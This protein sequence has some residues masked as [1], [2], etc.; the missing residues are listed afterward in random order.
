MADVLN[1]EVRDQV[2]TKRIR[3]MRKTGKIPAVLYGHKEAV[4]NLAIRKEEFAQVLKHSGKLVKLAGS[5]SEDALVREVQWDTYGVNVLHVDL[6][7]VSASERVTTEVTVELRGTAVGTTQGGVVQFITHELE[8]EC[9]AMSIPEK[10]VLNINDL[11]LGKAIHAHEVP[12]PEGVVLTSAP[13]VI[14]VQCVTP[15]V[16]EIPVPGA[17]GTAEPEVIGGKKPGEEEAA[18]TEKK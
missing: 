15:H 9:P 12:L 13:E 11:A 16:E 8:I 14:V 2:G 6:M 1:V 17:G 3:R 5:V 18:A 10:I 4:L 7:R